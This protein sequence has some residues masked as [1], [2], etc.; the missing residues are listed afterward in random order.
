MTMNAYQEQHFSANTRTT[1][2]APTRA[3]TEP[4]SAEARAIADRS[5]D[6]AHWDSS[7]FDAY[8]NLGG[9]Q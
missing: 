2:D 7:M 8:A 3:L 9:V 4:I 1:M 6:P 5:G